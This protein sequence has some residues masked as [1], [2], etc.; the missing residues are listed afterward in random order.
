MSKSILI[1]GWRGLP[2][3]YAMVNQYQCLE[4][5]RR[6]DI[7]LYFKYVP[8]ADPAWDLTPGLFSPDDEKAL[9][10]IPN[11]PEHVVPDAEFRIAFPF[12]FVSPPRARRTFVFGTSEYQFVSPDY[13]TGKVSLAEAHALHDGRITIVT[14][15]NWSRDGFVESG[16]DPKRVVVVPHGVDTSLY[17][18]PTSQ[19]RSA[20]RTKHN[21]AENEF[22]FL[23]IGAMTGNK[24]VAMLLRSFASVLR[25]HPT[26]K[27]FLKGIDS[28]FPSKKLFMTAALQSL[29]GDDAALALP[30]V[31]Y[32]GS[33]LSGVEMRE[34]YHAADC[35]VSPYTAEGFNLPVLEAAAT[36][37][38]IICT[39][40]GSTDDFTTDEF[41]WRI[42]S[43][44]V[45]N[46]VN[47]A[48]AHSLLPD[49]E[50]LRLLMR[51]VVVGDRFRKQASEKGPDFV[52]GGF[53]WR[54]VVDRL[55]AIF[56]PA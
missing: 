50:H 20:A 45:T 9:L 27:L 13:I 35:Y 26:A 12:D 30:R 51:D 10:E 25:E 48:A 55:L 39:A 44:P 28:L 3:S 17:Y 5:L 18:P 56:F 54:H 21:I 29:N 31:V 42:N 15:S 46:D 52:A 16:A 11:L 6:E 24:N 22:V 33:S 36:G 19:Q 53:T 43:T 37:I 41:T 2:H 14:P 34:I 40:G 8:L 47:G 23:N 38:P 1:S 4:L 7:R 49:E 32:I